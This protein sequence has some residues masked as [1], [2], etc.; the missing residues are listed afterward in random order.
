MTYSV[1]YQDRGGDLYQFKRV[2]APTHQAALHFM[3]AALLRSG[4]V[5][6]SP[7]ELFPGAWTVRELVP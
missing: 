6:A 2:R 1:S 4:R 5:T 3:R 7:Q